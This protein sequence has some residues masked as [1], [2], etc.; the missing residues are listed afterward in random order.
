MSEARTVAQL[1][2]STGA[3]ADSGKIP[4]GG[5]TDLEAETL[6][7]AVD[8]TSFTGTAPTLDISIEWSFDDGATFIAPTPAV[9]FAQITGPTSEIIS[10][11]V[12]APDYR[13]VYTWGGTV[14]DADLTVREFI[15]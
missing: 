8:V 9:A 12:L 15:R 13:L 10:T 2:D 3:E 7:L 4:V 6:V 14:T 11:P 5:A 1:V